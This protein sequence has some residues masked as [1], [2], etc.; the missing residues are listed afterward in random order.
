MLLQM[1]FNISNVIKITQL[2]WWH[3]ERKLFSGDSNLT[4]VFMAAVDIAA[5]ATAAAATASYS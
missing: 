3:P 1:L 2:M 4:A 5:A